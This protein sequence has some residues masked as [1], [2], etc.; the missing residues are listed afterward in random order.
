[1]ADWRLPKPNWNAVFSARPDLSLKNRY[2]RLFLILFVIDAALR[3]IWLSQPTGSLIFDEWYYVNVARV[4][5]GLPQSLGSNGQPP[6]ANAIPGLDPNHEHFPLAKLFIALSMYTLGDNGYGWRVPSV[7]FGSMALLVFYLLM[8]KTSKFEQV[9]IIATFLFSFDTLSFVLGR[10]AI[11]DIFTLTF[12]LLG[13]YWYFSGHS[14]LS[15]F[16]MALATLTKITGAAGFAIIAITHI[17]RTMRNRGRKRVWD[18]Y[19]S[20]FEKY[21]LVFLFSFLVILTVLDRLWVGYSNPFEHIQFIL[22]YSSSLVSACPNGI[23][24]C[25]WQWLVNQI[26]IPY[27][28]VNVQVTTGEIA[29]KYDSVAF[30]GMMNPTILYLTIPAML[31]LS[32]TYFTKED[33]FS[34]FNL[35]WFAVAYLPYLPAVILGH[36]VTYLF[37]LLPAIPAVCAAIAH[38]IADQNPPKLVVLFYL[39]VVAVWFFS[40]FPFKVIPT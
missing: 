10:I 33:D 27:L 40:A 3:S 35:V 12:M 4:I 32:Y 5:L 34:S 26:Q 36:R 2:D 38:M 16:G 24:S 21:F 1:L 13:F 39:G 31:Y 7:I 15:A 28:I 18:T 20:W 25:P 19:F 14:Y 11:L 37:Y 6:Y 17:F 29:T 22:S 30:W 8:K 23:I 9:P